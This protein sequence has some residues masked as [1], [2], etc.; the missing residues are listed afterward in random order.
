MLKYSQLVL[1]PKLSFNTKV[2]QDGTLFL[3]V[4]FIWLM[5]CII[6]TK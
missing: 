6:V 5:R 4:I 3:L 2:F 1:Q